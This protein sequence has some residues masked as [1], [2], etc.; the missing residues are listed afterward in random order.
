MGRIHTIERRSADVLR[1]P[2]AAPA[3]WL[4][5]E[6]RVSLFAQHLGT[7][8]PVSEHRVVAELNR[9]SPPT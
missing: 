5:Q 7:A 6:L 1:L 3:R 4:L 9:I 8:E 2:E